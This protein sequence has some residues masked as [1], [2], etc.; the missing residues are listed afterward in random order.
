MAGLQAVRDDR[1]QPVL[2]CVAHAV[3]SS[4]TQ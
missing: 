1:F 4:L 3:Q 2:D